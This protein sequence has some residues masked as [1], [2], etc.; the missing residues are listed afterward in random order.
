MGGLASYAWRTLAARPLRSLLT[1]VG[2]ALGVA[3]LF[4]ALTTNAGIE[5]AIGRTVGDLLG[6]A[7]LRV[8][9]F[10]ERGLSAASLAAIGET[11]GVD[12]ASPIL[13]RRTYLAPDP[14][15][16]PAPTLPPPVTVLGIDPATYAE[17]HDLDL[18]AG[19]G[20]AD[21]DAVGALITERMAREAGL[22]L[23][24]TIALQ[25]AGEPRPEPIV[26]ILSG[27]GPLATT[28]GRTVLVGLAEARSAF[29]LDGV[30]RVDIGLGAGA[31]TDAVAV[32]LERRLTAEP[33][34]LSI[35]ADLAA[36][37]RASTIDFQ[38]TSALIAAL[39]LFGGAFLIFNTLSMTV[40]E[41]AR[42]VGL[43]RV[44]GATRRQV[45]GLVLVQ[46]LVLGLAGAAV[47]L[48]LGSG[49]AAAV[50]WYLRSDGIVPIDGP[51]LGPSSVALALGVGTLVALAA[52][53]EPADRAGR[54]PPIEAL[55]PAGIGQTFRARLR[56]LVVVFLVVAL[57]G[58]VLW[59]ATA[60]GAGV[61][62]WLAV[63]GILLAATLLTPVLLGP[64]GTVAAVPFRLI[65]PGAA[66]LNRG[67]LTRDRSR[68]TLT[69]GALTVG[70]AMI[71]AL[72]GVA[73]DAR[74]AAT[75]W[76]AGVVPGEVIASSI[77]PVGIDEP[78]RADLAAAPGVARVS[79]LATFEVA[80]RGIRLDAA[81]VSGADLLADG[82]LT[83]VD[84]ERTAA[85]NAL[86]A[87]G[88]AIVP[89]G[90]A[91]SLGL[92]VGDALVFPV[93]GGRD[94]TLRVVG[95]AE[96]TIPGRTGETILVG[97]PDAGDGFGVT[98]ADAFAVRFRPEATA[99]QRDGLATI[100]RNDGLEANPVERIAGAVDDALSRV[101]GLFDVLALI[102]VII[103]ALGIVN[104][105][106]M[107]VYERVREIGVLRAAGMTRPQVW[108]MV[109]VEAGVL[110]IV[111]ATLGCVTGLLAGQAMI[112]LA[113]GAGLS[114][115]FEPDWRTIL[116][117]A[118][119]GIVVA[120]LAAIWP[121][122]LAS[123]ASIVRAIQYE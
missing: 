113:G 55:R 95:V 11:P 42:E 96:R 118:A 35:P 22:S 9:G 43:L 122:R 45:N 82:R 75:A 28:D 29:G 21:E 70:L 1:M 3:V 38:A 56:W 52:A 24:G 102:A 30:S 107:N 19:V 77:R 100:A 31:M 78:V 94:V 15:A 66:R 80:F 67:T 13:E 106:T 65:A 12:V 97:W 16:P 2:I 114:L 58:V 74:R 51:V 39:A 83:I 32:E 7:D 116:A 20:L 34:V 47:G 46:A 49:L 10:T 105:L 23:G 8:E 120:M 112:G 53:L 27:D 87:G 117:A 59:P 6:R 86:D 98:G 108:R 89:A 115:P 48:I 5:A 73:H 62:R 79:P 88:S 44:A 101:F 72:G 40:A 54:I 76:I 14:L 123:R 109:V 121:A 93:G 91:R 60:G 36:T 99:A 68:T 4:S 18:A 64:L 33:Y 63:Y 84:G 69:V 26:G 90:A 81:A 92:R 111:G 17:L 61:V 119:F 41:R 103:A 37:I 71:V 85:L 50:A 104:T 110:G 25:G 57:A